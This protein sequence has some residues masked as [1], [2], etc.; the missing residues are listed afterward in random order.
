MLMRPRTASQCRVP[1]RMA[2]G[3]KMAGSPQGGQEAAGRHPPGPD[4]ATGS[5]RLC[6]GWR[7]LVLLLRLLRLVQAPLGLLLLG[8]PPRPPQG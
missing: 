1:Q 5:W 8:L 6:V 4:R 7:P 3:P 2:D